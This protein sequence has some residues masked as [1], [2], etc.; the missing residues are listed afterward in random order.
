MADSEPPGIA[1]S[2]KFDQSAHSTAAFAGF[3]DSTVLWP[4]RK[5]DTVLAEATNG[6]G[7]LI[8]AVDR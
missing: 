7:F 5:T 2:V 6:V 1:A 3:D 4:D 8:L